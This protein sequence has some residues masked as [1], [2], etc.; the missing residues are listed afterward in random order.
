MG[1]EILYRKKS[2]EKIISQR[3]INRV[4]LVCGKSSYR[5]SGA[6]EYIDSL[7]LEKVI[8][9]GFSPNPKYE[10]VCDGVRAF[11]ESGCDVILAVGGGSALDTAKCIKLYDSMDQ[12]RPYYEQTPCETGVLL[13]AMPATAGS[14]SESTR[15]VVIYRDGVK[16]SLSF[17]EALPDYAVMEPDFL[18]SLPLYQRK[19]TM[20]DALCHGIESWWAK[21]SSRKSRTYA[22]M[23]VRVIGMLWRSY[24]F[25][26]KHFTEMLY[27]ANLAGQAINISKTT[28]A[29]AMSYGLTT[30]YGLSHGHAAALCLEQVWGGRDIEGVSSLMGSSKFSDILKELEM[31]RPVSSDRKRDIE[32][33]TAK[34]NPE[35]LSNHPVA[36]QKD[37]ISAMYERIIKT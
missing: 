31:E 30:M 1:Q 5:L 15:H 6:S 3:G 32:I 2:L 17:E 28:A 24:V 37:E 13:I 27:A 11:R 23:A 25:E 18:Q 9:S 36:L 14:G 8:F 10:E 20:L 7:P 21:D 4:F 26:G 33:L 22:H 34:V 19:S 35:R 16:Q 29:H 12:T